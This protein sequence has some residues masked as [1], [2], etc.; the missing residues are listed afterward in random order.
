MPEPA[1]QAGGPAHASSAS[2]A[3]GA[4]ALGCAGGGGAGDM[5]RT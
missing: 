5:E 3:M 4:A 1:H 2:S